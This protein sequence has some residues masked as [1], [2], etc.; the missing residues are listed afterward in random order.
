MTANN[1]DK[2]TLVWRNDPTAPQEEFILLF[3]DVGTQGAPYGST[4]SLR[5]ITTGVSCSRRGG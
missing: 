5:T 2:H 4:N 1:F 3:D